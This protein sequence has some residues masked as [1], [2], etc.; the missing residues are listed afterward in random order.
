M[1]IKFVAY[2][3]T[4]T[5]KIIHDE[6]IDIIILNHNH[7][8]TNQPNEFFVEDENRRN[9]RNIEKIHNINRILESKLM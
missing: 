6:H 9:E 4:Y 7:I 1:Y 5:H 8:D 3:T 2:T